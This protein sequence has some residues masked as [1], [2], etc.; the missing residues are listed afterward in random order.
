VNERLSR[1]LIDT[2]ESIMGDIGPSLQRHDVRSVPYEPLGPTRATI[3]SPEPT[4]GPNPNPDP[5]PTP[6]PGP[7]PGPDPTPVPSEQDPRNP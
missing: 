4:P 1:Q 7:G 3:P 6:E 5:V 2:E